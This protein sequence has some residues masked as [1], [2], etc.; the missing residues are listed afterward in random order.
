M[1]IKIDL[2]KVEALASRGLTYE[3]IAISLGMDSSTLWRKRQKSQ[4]LQDAIK[5]GKEKGITLIANRLFE[6]ASKG[7]IAAMIFFLKAQGGWKE[8]Q[9]VEQKISVDEKEAAKQ[10]SNEELMKIA[11]LDEGLEDGGGEGVAEKS[12]GTEAE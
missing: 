5:R 10:L 3:Q 9:I 6:E 7:N 11:G 8:K 1:T 4:K 2:A 12:V